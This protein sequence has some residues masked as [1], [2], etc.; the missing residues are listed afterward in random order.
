MLEN[1]WQHIA[2]DFDTSQGCAPS[3]RVAGPNHQL[4]IVRF[5]NGLDH[6]DEHSICF[7]MVRGQ[8]LSVK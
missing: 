3:Q 8:K 2:C 6:C 5:S 1:E 4:F 7:H